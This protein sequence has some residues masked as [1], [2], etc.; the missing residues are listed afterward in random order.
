MS[1]LTTDCH[2]HSG[3]HQSPHWT[4]ISP[5]EMAHL[6]ASIWIMHLAL[7]IRSQLLRYSVSIR[8]VQDF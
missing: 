5:P 2:L 4:R 7:G 8:D 1:V 6:N 3:K